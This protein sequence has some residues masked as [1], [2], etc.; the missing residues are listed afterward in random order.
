[1]S[2]FVPRPSREPVRNCSQVNREVSKLIV[3]T[4]ASH[5]LS[6]ECLVSVQRRGEEEGAGMDSPTLSTPGEDSG[7]LPTRSYIM[8]WNHGGEVAG[9]VG[10]E[11]EAET[12]LTS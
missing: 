2:G 9:Q 10:R 1:V 4:I 3:D 8:L 12:D 7:E 6:T 11:E 5:L